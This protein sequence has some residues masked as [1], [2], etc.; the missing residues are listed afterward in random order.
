MPAVQRRQP[1]E[2][3]ITPER[4]R[5]G[6]VERVPETIADDAGAISF[7]FRAIDNLAALLKRDEITPEMFAAG[8]QFED[9]FRRSQLDSLQAA[10]M[11]RVISAG[12]RTREDSSRAIR[13]RDAIYQALQ[14]LGGFD[15]I[16]S[17]I[18]WHVL[19]WQRSIKSWAIEAGLNQQ[20]AKGILIASLDR[21]VAHYGL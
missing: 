14:A 7:P 9:E 17:R 11:S 8:R 19:G 13:A 4:F 16:A 6:L 12:N 18:A 5:R 10:D 2:Q 21:L 3:V 1:D 20:V 15:T